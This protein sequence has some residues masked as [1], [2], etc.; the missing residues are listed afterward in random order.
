LLGALVYIISEPLS[1]ELQQGT[2]DLAVAYEQLKRQWPDGTVFQKT[3]AGWL[4]AS[5]DVYQTLSGEQGNT[6]LQAFFH[7][8][9]GFFELVTKLVIVLI[10]SIYWSADHVH[11][12]RLWLSVLPAGHRARSREVWR[13][14]EERIGGYIG[15]EL[16]QSILAGLLLGGGYWLLG[17]EYPTLLALTGAILRLIPML[18]VALAV[19]P[20]LLVGMTSSLSQ[21]IIAALYTFITLLVLEVIIKRRLFKQQLASPILVVLLIMI[22]ADAFGILGLLVAPPLAAAIQLVFSNLVKNQTFATNPTAP[23]RGVSELRQRLARLTEMIDSKEEPVS[24]EI[25]DIRE[26]LTG[27]LEKID[28]VLL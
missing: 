13:S 15:G 20:A 24:M 10:L 23:T 11:F 7:F 6:L 2:D 25:T 12:E 8:T 9:S 5:E 19:V 1:Y 26:R 18:G 27:L 17:L 4:P 14:G 16:M 28:Q 22:M 21:G 3:V